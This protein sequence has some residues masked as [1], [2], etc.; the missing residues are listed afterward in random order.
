MTL[1]QIF[2]A[3]DTTWPVMREF[4]KKGPAI[5]ALAEEIARLAKGG[6]EGLSEDEC[7]ER[8]VRAMPRAFD[9]WP[10]MVTMRNFWFET[11][12]PADSIYR[13]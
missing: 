3:L 9:F 13:K 10:G 1:Q 5:L 7:I 2:T 6:Y 8:F 4:P 11:F 12:P